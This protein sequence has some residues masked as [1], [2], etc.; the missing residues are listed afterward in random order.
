MTRTDA[1]YNALVASRLLAIVRYREGGDVARAVEE[2]ADGGIRAIEVTTNTPGWQQAVA[3]VAVRADLAVGVGTVTDVAQLDE[4]V[5]SGASFIVSPGFDAE[6]TRAAFAR[7]LEVVAGVATAT[8]IQAATRAGMR[9]LKL[10][11]AGALGTAYLR[12]LRGPFDDSAFVVTGGIGVDDV[13]TWFDAGA[14][15]VSLGSDLTGAAVPETAEGWR[16][17]RERAA[18][19]VA[20]LG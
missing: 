8:E 9:L 5:A 4:V 7:G 6:V 19:A 12:Q 3:C 10:F 15:I 18:A 11:P 2:I 17:L 13:R 14:A 1:A 20:A 16:A